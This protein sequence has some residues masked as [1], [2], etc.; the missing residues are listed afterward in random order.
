MEKDNKISIGFL[1]TIALIL[2][3]CPDSSRIDMVRV[4][5]GSFDMGSTSGDSEEKPVHRV[6]VSSFFINKYEV[7]L[8]LYEE[9][10]GNNPSDFS[11]ENNPVEEVTWQQLSW[12]PPAPAHCS[13]ASSNGKS[14]RNDS[15]SARIP[16][17]FSPKCDTR[18]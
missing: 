15:S 7:T 6:T 17:D 10:M 1:A 14:H 13:I 4:E 12:F 16:F 5:G 18:R 9:V 2:S 11:G 3:G 8:K